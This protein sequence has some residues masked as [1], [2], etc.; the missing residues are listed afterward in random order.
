MKLGDKKK[1]KCD[2]SEKGHKVAKRGD[3]ITFQEELKHTNAGIIYLFHNNEGKNLW[4]LES[5]YRK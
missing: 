5:Q 3:E 2:L 1:M 4:L